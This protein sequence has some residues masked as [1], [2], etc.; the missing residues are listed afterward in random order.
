MYVSMCVCT[1]MYKC[2]CGMHKYINKTFFIPYC[3]LYLY[4]CR[5]DY[6][7]LDTDFGEQ[8]GKTNFP[9]LSGH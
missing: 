9:S 7:V 2:V 6:F 8:L 5:A 1:N 4:D 3:F